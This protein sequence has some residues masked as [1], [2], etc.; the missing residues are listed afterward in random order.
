VVWQEPVGAIQAAGAQRSLDGQYDALSGQYQAALTAPA[1]TTVAQAPGRSYRTAMLERAHLAGRLNVTRRSGAALGRIRIP[2]IGLSKVWV[3]GTDSQALTQGPG[4]Y[5]GTVLPGRRGTVGIAGH[6][7]THGAPFRDINRVHV[8]DRILVS[9]PYGAYTYRV[10]GTQI[11]SP[12]N[13]K[14]LQPA[15]ADRLVLT[16]CHPL[17]S[18]AQRIVVTAQLVSWPLSDRR[19]TAV[20]PAPAAG[21]A[22]K[23]K[24]RGLGSTPRAVTWIF[25]KA[26]LDRLAPAEG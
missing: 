9:M 2:S 20:A 14:V 21:A 16:A 8:G 22:P 13:V 15:R 10:Q 23:R 5:A 7:T 4:H 6:R 3:Q 12:E 1:T 17:W 24:R 19:P 25:G 18:A 11:V 26:P